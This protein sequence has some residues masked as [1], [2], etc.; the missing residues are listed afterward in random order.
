M[1]I[2]PTPDSARKRKSAGEGSS[3][4]LQRPRTSYTQRLA[5]A[6][7]A[8]LGYIAGNIPGAVIG[9]NAANMAYRA[10]YGG[11]GTQRRR[12]RIRKSYRKFSNK[13]TPGAVGVQ[14]DVVTQ[15][16]YKKMPRYKKKSWKKFSKKV[17]AVIGKGLGLQTVVF[18]DKMESVTA[19]NGQQWV[20]AL[21]YGN[22]GSEDKLSSVGNQDLWRIFNNEPG[23]NKNP[24]TNPDT[25]LSGKL[26]FQSACIDLTIRNMSAD[27]EAEV[28]VYFGYFLKS[29]VAYNTDAA[30]KTLRD[31]FYDIQTGTG[32]VIQTGN[33]L[34]TL[35]QRGVTPFECTNA[36][37]RTTFHITKKQKM[38]MQPGKSVFLQ[39]RDSANH[40]LEWS[41]I[42]Q[43]S[44]GLKG[45]TF[46]VLIV[47]KPTVSTSTTLVSTLVVGVTRKYSYSVV[48]ENI[49]KC[50]YDFGT[51]N[52]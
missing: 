8:T 34:C 41:N 27:N 44:Y 7:G 13:R 37:S 50:A 36:L 6:S 5:Q 29:Q 47:H 19:A 3:R 16:R 26:H 20:T 2:P 45:L 33:S 14:R 18:N 40:I 30:K 4:P 35:D 38:D 25:P 46:G 28:D 24:A 43:F 31:D 49:D 9:Y 21:L 32:V 12:M 10:R 17:N 1:Y 23:I 22:N 48:E 51:F 39:H 11:R 52:S 42:S 15:Y